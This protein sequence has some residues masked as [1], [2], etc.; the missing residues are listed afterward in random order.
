MVDVADAVDDDNGFCVVV[1]VVND[2]DDD[3]ANVVD[4]CGLIRAL[5]GVVLAPPSL[6]PVL[7][8]VLLWGVSGRGSRWSNGAISST[9]QPSSEKSAGLWSILWLI[10]TTTRGDPLREGGNA[11]GNG[12]SRRGMAWLRWW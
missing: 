12:E 4:D 6:P 5:I 8:P 9:S 10:G 3:G 1:V 7:F 11:V 2:D